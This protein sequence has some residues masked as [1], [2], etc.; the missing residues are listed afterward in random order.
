MTRYLIDI[1]FRWVYFMCMH[2]Y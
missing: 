2:Y 1:K